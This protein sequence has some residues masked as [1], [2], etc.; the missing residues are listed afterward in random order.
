MVHRLVLPAVLLTV[1]PALTS[2]EMTVPLMGQ[3]MV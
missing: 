1:S 3:V 2:L